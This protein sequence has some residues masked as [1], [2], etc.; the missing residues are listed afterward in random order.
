MKCLPVSDILF[1]TANLAVHGWKMRSI[2]RYEEDQG[3]IY[4]FYAYAVGDEYQPSLIC[5]T[6]PELVVER[7]IC[8]PERQEY[9]VEFCDGLADFMQLK[10][11]LCFPEELAG[12]W[13]VSEAHQRSYY[14]RHP[15]RNAL[16]DYAKWPLHP[17]FMPDREYIRIIPD[18]IAS[19]IEYIYRPDLQADST[20][21]YLTP[22]GIGSLFGRTT[23]EV[24]A[25]L[26]ELGLLDALG[27]LTGMAWIGGYIQKT[28]YKENDTCEYA[29]NKD[30]ICS[31]LNG[32]GWHTVT[33]GHVQK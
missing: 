24:E 32:L 25:A 3:D 15:I 4:L 18:D 13:H 31:E 5:V 11:P 14:L 22:N 26:Q 28:K 33:P 8:Q 20:V 12:Y 6:T 21:V 16:W 27:Q 1:T 7:L 10:A 29:W 17:D 9:E 30:R 19:S 2:W 23:A